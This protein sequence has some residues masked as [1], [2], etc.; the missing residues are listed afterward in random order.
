MYV[1]IGVIGAMVAVVAVVGDEVLVALTCWEWL[2]FLDPPWIWVDLHTALCPF[3]WHCITVS[4]QDGCTFIICVS[5]CLFS[6]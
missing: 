6:L 3:L 4:Y 5:H 2:F 1:L